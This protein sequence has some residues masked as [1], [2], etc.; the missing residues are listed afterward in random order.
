VPGS[1]AQRLSAAARQ[2][3]TTVST[4]RYSHRSAIDADSGTIITDCSGLLTWLLQRELPEHLTAIAN[5]RGRTHPL[6]ADFEEAFAAGA[7]G[8]QRI[9]R[10]QDAQP[11][12]VLAWRYLHP[13]PGRSSG[14]VMIIDSA[15]TEDGDGIVAIDVIDSTSA[16]HDDD[17]RIDTSGVGRGTIHFRIDGAGAPLE[18]R[19]GATASF[20]R[21]AFAIARPVNP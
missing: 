17:S 11:G 4:T 10:I 9:A 7:A 2:L 13:K 20:V 15:A 18:V 5:K 19:T 16:P 6:A 12:D 8:W 3:L 21:H 1:P 14:H